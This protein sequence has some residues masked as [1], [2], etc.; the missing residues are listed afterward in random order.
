MSA[1]APD[2]VVVGPVTR[3]VS[4]LI[5]AVPPAGGSAVAGETRV[6]PGGKGGNPAVC[7]ARLGARVRLLGAV[8]DDDAGREVLAGLAA[9]GIDV[10]GV[11]RCAGATTGQIMHLVEPG[12]ARRYVESRGANAALELGRERVAAACRPGTV[13]LVSTA[14]PAA[15]VNDAVFGAAGAGARVVADLAGEVDTSRA[16]LAGADVVRGDADE[17]GE[18]TGCPV[19]DFASARRAAERLLAQGPGIAIVQAGGDGDLVLAG[20]R[21]IRLPHLPVRPVDPTGAGDALV[22]TFAV[23]CARG[24]DLERAARLGAAAAAHTVGH[25]GGRP[26]FADE[27]ELAALA[28]RER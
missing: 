27:A 17:I 11:L 9:D 24:A 14:L 20:D 21:E 10:G 13:A 7:A 18:L 26:A 4:L 12:G 6:A 22:T 19:H 15:A 23:L 16:I 5:D 1:P 8:G 2:V 28:D 25:L 3:D